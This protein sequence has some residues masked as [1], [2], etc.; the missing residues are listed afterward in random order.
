MN[1]HVYVGW[2]VSLSCVCM[3]ACGFVC[4]MCVP[5]CVCVCVCV[6]VCGVCVC[7]CE[8]ILVYLLYKAEKSSVCPSA[9]IVGFVSSRSQPCQ[10][11]STS[12]LLKTKRPTSGMTKFIF[13]SF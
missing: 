9:F 2:Y 3:C 10:H 13:K 12:N 5:I 8:Y 11:R 6:C 1:V 7:K 4:V